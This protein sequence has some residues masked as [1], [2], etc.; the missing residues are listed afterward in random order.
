MPAVVAYNAL[1]KRLDDLLSEI[2]AASDGWV[3]LVAEVP[4][5]PARVEKSA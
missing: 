4:A 1:N 3:A 5:A 2:E